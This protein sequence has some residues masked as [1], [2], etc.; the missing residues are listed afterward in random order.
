MSYPKLTAGAIALALALFALPAASENPGAANA[1]DPRS[2]NTQTHDARNATA[3]DAYAQNA[4]A[5]DAHAQDAHG[6]DAHAHDAHGKDTHAHAA[7]A[8]TKAVA[9]LSSVA[10]SGVRG[11]VV[12]EQT[13]EGVRVVAEVSGLTPGKHGFHIH[14]FGD[15]SAADYTSAGG[16]FMAPGESHGAPGQSHSHLGD[17]GNLEADAQGNARLELVDGKFRFDGPTSILGRAVIVHAKED[18]LKTQPTGDAGGRVAC[19]TIGIAKS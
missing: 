8:V 13:D 12:F 9:V 4:K 11:T 5:S 16:H 15:C 3:H 1:Q 17:L 18:D 6:H 2:Q 10:G 14:E 7:P 19:G